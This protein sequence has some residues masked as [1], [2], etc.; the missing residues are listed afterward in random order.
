M[1]ASAEEKAREETAVE[2]PPCD[3]KCGRLRS[4]LDYLD[5][6]ASALDLGIFVMMMRYTGI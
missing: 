6:L 1:G 4:G 5:D 3:L 2:E